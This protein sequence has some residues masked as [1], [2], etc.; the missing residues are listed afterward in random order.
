MA[1]ADL[2]LPPLAAEDARDQRQLLFNRP[3]QRSSHADFLSSRS[4][5][6]ESTTASESLTRDMKHYTLRSSVR[7]FLCYVV[8]AKVFRRAGQFAQVVAQSIRGVRPPLTGGGVRKDQMAA[9]TESRSGEGAEK[10]E[11]R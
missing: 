1:A 7:S 10:E 6:P 4:D 11:I 3:L 9:A 5:Y 2:G 8:S